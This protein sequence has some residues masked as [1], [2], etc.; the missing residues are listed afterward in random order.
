MTATQTLF[1]VVSFILLIPLLIK[2]RR[3][4]FGEIA[5]S[6]IFSKGIFFGIE[7]ENIITLFGIIFHLIFLFLLWYQKPELG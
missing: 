7:M 4:L 5:P 2:L 1:G 3:L 6:A